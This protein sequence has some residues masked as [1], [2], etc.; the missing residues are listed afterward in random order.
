MPHAEFEEKEFEQAAAIELAD[1]PPGQRAIVLS[2]GQVLERIVGYDAVTAPA[3]EHV[4]W[5]LLRVRRPGGLCLVPELWLPGRQ[6]P[7]DRLPRSAISL[8]LQFKRPD[9]L[10]GHRAAQWHMWHQPFY[11]FRRLSHQHAIL[12]RLERQLGDQALVR[13]AAPAF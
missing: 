3:R 9:Y 7:A 2:A 1:G 13:Y 12:L 10:F 4:I 6:P 11:R 5:Q 8:V